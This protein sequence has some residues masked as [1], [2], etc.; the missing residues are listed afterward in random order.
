MGFDAAALKGGYAAWRS[1]YPV[2][3][4]TIEEASQA[5]THT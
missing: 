5:G 4:K 2:E 3:R 1:A